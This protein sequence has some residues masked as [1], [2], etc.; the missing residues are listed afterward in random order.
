MLLHICTI[1]F[2]IP[3]QTGVA[4]EINIVIIVNNQIH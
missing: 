2:N 1:L 4:R 3:D